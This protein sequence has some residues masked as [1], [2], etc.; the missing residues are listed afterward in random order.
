MY[1]KL[2]VIIII[3]EARKGENL[4]KLLCRVGNNP[5]WWKKWPHCA[6]SGVL[7]YRVPRGRIGGR[8]WDG[9]CVPQ[10]Y[11]KHTTTSS[12]PVNFQKPQ[13]WFSTVQHI[14][15][16]CPFVC[17]SVSHHSLETTFPANSSIPS[18]FYIIFKWLT[19]FILFSLF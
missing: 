17:Y 2:Y 16:W 14:I 3:I 5:V 11:T 6:P 15:I 7:H 19:F 18:Q 9:N 1:K 13:Y 4:R 8:G 12:V 10:L